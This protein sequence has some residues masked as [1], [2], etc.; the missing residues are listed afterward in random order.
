MGGFTVVWVLAIGA[1]LVYSGVRWYLS[2]EQ[3]AKRALR[4]AQQ[5]P[6]R[7]VRD[8]Q[9]VKVC[10]RLRYVG[11]PLVA[12]LS[13]R[14]CGAWRV[15]VDEYQSRGKGG[16]WHNVITE[17]EAGDIELDDGTGTARVSA[18]GAQ[19]VVV[20][21]AHYSSG[22]FNDPTPVLERY[23]AKHGQEATG[24]L[25]FNKGFRY[26][27]GALEEGEEVA[28]LGV[29]RWQHHPRAEARGA[30]GY[31]ELPRRLVL[32]PPAAAALIVSDDPSV[33]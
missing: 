6:I 33:L 17:T 20:K 15:E 16:S 28:V 5:L 19:L 30:R 31:R 32:E 13:G 26:R 8:G 3:K 22:T 25:G 9:V 18:L 7:E 4:E 21:D 11:E 1:V 24:M 2:D 23:L 29:A 14:R 27:E 12:P 10:G